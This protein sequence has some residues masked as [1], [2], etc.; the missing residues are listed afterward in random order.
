[1]VI[2]MMSNGLWYAQAALHLIYPGKIDEAAMLADLSC[3][4]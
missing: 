2:V 4:V 1:M 3:N